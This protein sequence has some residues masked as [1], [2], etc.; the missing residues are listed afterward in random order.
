MIDFYPDDMTY[1][2]KERCLGARHG[3]EPLLSEIT[4]REPAVTGRT[5]FRHHRARCQPTE[6]PRK[7]HP[8]L[9]H[10]DEQVIGKAFSF[11]DGL[12]KHY[13]RAEVLNGENLDN[14]PCLTVAT[15]NGGMYAPDILCLMVEYWH[16][17]GTSSPAFGMGHSIIFKIPYFGQLL[18]G[19]GVIPACRENANIVLQQ[20]HPL[21]LCPGG[22]VDSLKPFS[23]R[24]RVM[25]NGRNGFIRIAIQNQVPIVPVVSVGAH[26]IFFIL[27]DG[28]RLAELIGLAKYF[29]IKS[30]PIA[31]SFPLG[32]TPA[33]IL[34]IPLPSKVTVQILPK[35]ELGEPVSAAKDAKRVARCYNYVQQVMQQALNQLSSR[36]KWPIWG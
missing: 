7:I 10:R 14:G 9:A 21:F 27:N 3:A 26:E 4:E 5:M 34:S 18:R 15:H 8:L 36:R 16:R 24:H 25:F 19:L 23:Q 12:V 29:R 1:Q 22:D 6:P 32:L 33:G 35:I 31:L 11:L 30:V 2:P 17:F 20:G 28:R 13:F